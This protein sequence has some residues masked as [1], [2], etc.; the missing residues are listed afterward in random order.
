MNIRPLKIFLVILAVIFLSSCAIT[1]RD[2]HH[3]GDRHWHSSLQ[4]PDQP[5]V[6][7]TAQ[8]SGVQGTVGR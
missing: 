4:Q 8:N 6:Q 3:P 7:I 2:H 5:P 1:V